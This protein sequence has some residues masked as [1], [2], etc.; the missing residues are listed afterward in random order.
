MGTLT[1]SFPGRRTKAGEGGFLSVHLSQGRIELTSGDC[2]V[3]LNNVGMLRGPDS[4]THAWVVPTCPAHVYLCA[5][6]GVLVGTGGSLRVFFWPW[7]PAPPADKAG[8]GA[9][10]VEA[11]G[12]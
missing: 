9:G 3:R 6:S 10:A 7:E 5:E 8:W 4:S 2:C 12:V 1:R 11:E